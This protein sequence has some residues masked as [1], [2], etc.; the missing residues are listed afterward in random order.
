[1]NENE[2]NV[3]TTEKE[4]DP[5]QAY[6]EA[7]AE[8]KRNY[9]PRE[10]L[11]KSQAREKQLLEAMVS[12]KEIDMPKTEP[13]VDIQ[14]LRNELYGKDCGKLNSCE[15]INKTLQLRKALIEK[16]ERDPFI[17]VGDRAKTTPEMIE[18]AQ[19]VADGLQA[20]IDFAEGD[21]GIFL[22]EYQRRVTDPKLPIGRKRK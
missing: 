11:Q 22:A 8:V 7:M 20:M 4:L 9:V 3:E 10:E 13:K 21:E 16:G 5:A 15:Y 1:M 14:Q 12:G 17:T 2:Q 6:I 18:G 19:R